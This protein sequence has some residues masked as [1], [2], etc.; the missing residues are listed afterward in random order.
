MQERNKYE[1]QKQDF[2]FTLSRFSHEIRNP[3]ALIS[4]E[5]QMMAGSHPEVRTFSEWEDIL[6]NL[7]HI[8]CLLDELSGYQNAERLSLTETDLY[9]CLGSILN[10][11]RP[12]L[13]YLGITL[14]TCI[15]HTHSPSSLDRT[16]IRQAFLN[17]L[18]NAQEAI[19]DP[20]N[21]IIQVSA[22]AVPGGF[23]ITVRD[24]GC[25]MTA[26]Q[27]E[28]IFRPFVS[29]KPGGTGLGLAVTRQI[30][31]AHHGSLTVTSTPGIGSCFTVLLPGVDDKEV[32][33][34]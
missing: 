25:G 26:S 23:C 3:L 30:I 16:K 14:E 11:F 29:Y 8:R 15:P 5:L 19:P 31:E 17:L 1:Q 34:G 6:D 21:G 12:V 24:N 20:H 18:R 33:T 7:E 28:N 32:L 27:L 9:T 22:S 4:S 13:N 10:S 2:H